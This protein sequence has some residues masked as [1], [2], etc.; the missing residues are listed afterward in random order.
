M[1]PGQGEKG[2]EHLTDGMSRR[3]ELFRLRRKQNFR[4]SQKKKKNKLTRP[5]RRIDNPFVKN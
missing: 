3:S 1:P 5:S 4:F 2:C